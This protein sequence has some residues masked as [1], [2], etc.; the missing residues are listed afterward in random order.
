MTGDEGLL[1]AESNAQSFF[2]SYGR[3]SAFRR[4]R[5]LCLRKRGRGRRQQTDFPQQ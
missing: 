5:L 3:D 2:Y 4:A 1:I